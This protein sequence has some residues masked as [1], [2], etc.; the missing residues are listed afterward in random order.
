MY[1]SNNNV[2]LFISYNDD[3]SKLCKSH[4]N[5]DKMH[6]APDFSSDSCSCKD[7]KFQQI[8]NKLCNRTCF[9]SASFLMLSH[10]R[11]TAADQWP[12]AEGLRHI[13]FDKRPDDD[14]MNT[15]VFIFNAGFDHLRHGFRLQ[16]IGICRCSEV[17]IH[18]AGV[19]IA[20]TDAIFS[21]FLGEDLADAF[22]GIFGSAVTARH[23]V[24]EKAATA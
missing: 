22:H 7:E 13:L 9:S 6:C 23:G 17:G 14:V 16:V 8:D 12:A 3:V 20:N 5:L 10:D 11:T 21:G 2:F 4:G 24:I 1:N 19:N 18:A 15:T